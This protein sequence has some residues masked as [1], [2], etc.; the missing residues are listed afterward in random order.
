MGMKV[1]WIQ[2]TCINTMQEKEWHF[3]AV[4]FQSSW[5]SLSS[6]WNKISQHVNTSWL[7]LWTKHLYTHHA[8]IKIKI[9]W[10]SSDL[11]SHKIISLS[12]VGIAHLGFCKSPSRMHLAVFTTNLNEWIW[13]APG[14]PLT[15]QGW[16]TERTLC[17]CPHRTPSVERGR[18][19]SGDNRPASRRTWPCTF[20]KPSALEHSRLIQ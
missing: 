5:W 17:R 10:R 4:K 15:M 3:F 19:P 16:R 20:R 8:K 14:R 11:Q 12:W 2:G 6:S 1:K 9:K 13:P 7:L 18:T